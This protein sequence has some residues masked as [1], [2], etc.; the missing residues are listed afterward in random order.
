MKLPIMITTTTG[1]TCTLEL[2]GDNYIMK[3]ATGTHRLSEHCTDTKRLQAH[4]IGFVDNNGGIPFYDT[5]CDLKNA[6]ND[7]LDSALVK[8]IKENNEAVV[9]ML[10]NERSRRIRDRQQEI[11]QSELEWQNEI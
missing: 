1:H 2:V 9:D 6:S 4:W 11:A 8:A 3:G 5:I 10:F 7:I